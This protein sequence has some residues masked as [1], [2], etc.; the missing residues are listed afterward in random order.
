MEFQSIINSVKKSCHCKE[1]GNLL[2]VVDKTAERSFCVKCNKFVKFTID[3]LK[4]F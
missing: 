2:I 1:C 4:Q 3:T